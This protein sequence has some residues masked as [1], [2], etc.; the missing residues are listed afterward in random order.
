MAPEVLTEQ[1]DK[2]VDIWSLGITAIEMAEGDPPNHEL[3][4]F[5]LMIRLPKG[6]PPKLK[7]SELYS[8]DFVQFISACLQMDPKNRPTPK[9]LLEV[10]FKI[11]QLTV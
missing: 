3:Q 5:Q 11:I 2:N 10:F 4:P 1:Y 9:Q 7:Q 6:P 8:N